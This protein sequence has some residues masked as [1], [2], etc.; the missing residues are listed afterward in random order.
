MKISLNWLG[1]YAEWG[2]DVERLAEKLTMSGTEVESVTQS[3]VNVPNVVT[4]KIL[5]SEKHPNADRL[6]VCQVDDGKGARQVVCGA[7][8]YKV[9]DVVPLAMPGAKFPNGLE[10]K[11]SKLRGVQSDGMLCSAIELGLGTEAE[12]LL[13]LSPETPMGRPI[14]EIFPGDT[15]LELEVTP[16]RADLLSYRGVARELAVLGMKLKSAPVVKK[17]TFA[18]CHPWKL[19]VAELTHCPRYTAQLLTGVKVGPS[20]AWLRGRLEAVG[21]RSINNVVDITNYVLLELGQ[22]LHAF[23]AD[24]LKGRTI[25][26]RRAR[27]DEKFEALDGKAY[28]LGETDLVIADAER[29]VALA[30]VIGGA[31]TGVTETTTTVLLESASFR[32][33]TVR[34]S[35]RRHGLIT[36]SSYR[37]ERGIDPA[38]VDE[39]RERAVALLVEIA[40]ASVANLAWQTTPYALSQNIVSLRM[41]RARRFISM[42]VSDERMKEILAALGCE[43]L[44]KNKWRVPTWRPDL[45]REIDLIE[46]I[47]RIEGLSKAE[48]NF[49]LGV[50]AAT[51][52]DRTHQRDRE[53]RALL[54]SLGF[55]EI[56]TSSLLPRMEEAVTLKDPIN[57]DNVCLRQDL[58]SSALPCVVRNLAREQ[59]TVKMFEIGR[60]FKKEGTAWRE[61]TRLLI[62]ATGAERPAHW[63][64]AERRFDFFSLK[65][66]LET[67]RARFPEINLPE[68]FGAADVSLLKKHDIKVPVFAAEL[69]LPPAPKQSDV[70]FQPLPQY[71]AIARDLAF[72]VNRAVRNEEILQAIRSAN[73]AELESVECFDLF[74]DDEGKKLPKEKKSLA[75]TLTYRSSGRTLQESEVAAWERQIVERVGKATGAELRAG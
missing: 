16:N 73:I 53:L 10:I 46:E 20:P 63:T 51:E 75:Y 48:R 37:F 2:G 61:E 72:V 13:I 23:D 4:A 74:Q 42:D 8:N 50:S 27:A 18:E 6:S 70:K 67:V 12:G 32:P 25:C 40:G 28:T 36:D 26:V 24:Q 60:V 43:S 31:A 45:T 38:L 14:A 9:G 39:A 71:P 1:E 15:L 22:P 19:S 59:R 47:V 58:C 11:A 29:A 69:V 30:G 33:V 3:G 56:V 7:K 21:L 35:S 54:T 66:A 41:D 5:S 49:R 17:A 34:Q 65:G 57:E 55:Y 64:E 62:L 68:K 44:E 52:A